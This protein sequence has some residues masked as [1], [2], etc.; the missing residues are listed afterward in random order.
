MDWGYATFAVEQALPSLLVLA[1]PIPLL[2][3]FAE[4]RRK[5]L[6]C[7][8]NLFA[9]IGFVLSC[10]MAAMPVDD[11]H[12]FE[13]VPLAVLV[14]ATVML[15]PSI[16]VLRRKWLGIVHLATMAGAVFSLFVASMA[17]ARDLL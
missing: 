6:A 4:P 13:G 1:V 5:L 10:L 14:V 9:L 12:L 11:W 8:P 3:Y 2:V 17:L 15:V 16:L 7:S